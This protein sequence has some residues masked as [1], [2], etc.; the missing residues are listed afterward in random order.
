MDI[1]TFKEKKDHMLNHV[2]TGLSVFDCA[3]HFKNYVSL[4]CHRDSI[5]YKL[6][7]FPR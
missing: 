1:I 3:L 4:K 2:N 7:R 6:H 5:M